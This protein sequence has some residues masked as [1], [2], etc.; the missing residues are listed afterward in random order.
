MADREKIGLRYC[1]GCNS[2]YDRVALVRRMEAQFPGWDLV[3]ARPQT[4]YAALVVVCGC[5]A[6]CVNIRS[7]TTSAE[8][9]VYITDETEFDAACR[10]L[11]GIIQPQEE[12]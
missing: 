3:P 6:R 11:S 7:L 1:G 8:K 5:P 4:E 10:R 2:R 9:R 12:I